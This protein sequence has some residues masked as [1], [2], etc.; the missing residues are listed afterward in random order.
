MFEQL[1]KL[2][3]GVIPTQTW[4]SESSMLGVTVVIGIAN[5]SPIAL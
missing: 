5:L 2:R 3:Q 4:S 1:A